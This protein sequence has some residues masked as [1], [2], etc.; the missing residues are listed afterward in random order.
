VI[1]WMIQMASSMIVT[2]LNY[3]MDDTDSEQYDCYCS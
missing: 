1:I 3:Y 2:A